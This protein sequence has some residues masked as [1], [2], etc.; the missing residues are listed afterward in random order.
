MKII[1]EQ[2]SVW[3]SKGM[4]KHYNH[5]LKGSFGFGKILGLIDVGSSGITM[6]TSCL[7]AQLL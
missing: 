7:M 5:H 2:W 3:M 6:K 4:G 1:W